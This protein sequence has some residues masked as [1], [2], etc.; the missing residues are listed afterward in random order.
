MI[1]QL[2]RPD[3]VLKHA[4]DAVV[5]EGSSSE[6]IFARAHKDLNI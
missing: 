2:R 5:Y 4:D 6:G 3:L 1:C